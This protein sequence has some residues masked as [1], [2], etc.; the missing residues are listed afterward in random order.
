MFEKL[1]IPLLFAIVEGAN[2][3]ATPLSIA[4]WVKSVGH[5]AVG[6]FPAKLPV[7]VHL[8]PCTP[9]LLAQGSGGYS[10]TF[11]S[12]ITF[13]P[14]L[15]PVGLLLGMMRRSSSV[16]RVELGHLVSTFRFASVLARR[17]L[18]V[19]HASPFRRARM[20]QLHRLP[21]SVSRRGRHPLFVE[22]G[23]QGA[24]GQGP[25]LI[26]AGDHGLDVVLL[27][28]RVVAHWCLVWKFTIAAVFES[29]GL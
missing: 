26:D 1:F 19:R 15:V 11:V 20:Q 22:G 8:Q 23:S 3:E 18:V 6:V 9:V 12:R 27:D 4:G 16:G 13:R 29:G 2:N 21:L 5:S 17:L 14:C 24:Q 25:L 10:V 7:T 28:I